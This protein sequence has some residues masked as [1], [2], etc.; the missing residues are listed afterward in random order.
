MAGAR[1]RPSTR[2]LP[3]AADR[4]IPLASR[5]PRA[6]SERDAKNKRL[7]E[8]TRFTYS[9]MEWPGSRE[10]ST[11]GWGA[12]IRSLYLDRA[13]SNDDDDTVLWGVAMFDLGV[14]VI[15]VL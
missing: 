2:S 1:R 9:G 3:R 7:G 15:Y 5:I 4:A 14:T 11:G 12:E 8:P 13:E 6:R 10:T